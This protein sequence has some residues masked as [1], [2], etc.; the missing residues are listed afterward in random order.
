M[1]GGIALVLGYGLDW[2]GITPII[3]RIAT[4][5]FTFASGGWALVALAFFYWLVD[6]KKVQSWTRFFIVV[7]MNSIFIYLFAEV[8]GKAW[9]VDFVKIFNFGFFGALGLTESALNLLNALIT[10]GCMWGLC[11]FLYKKKI[12]FRV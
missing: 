2:L 12:F 4:T 5:S 6:V 8:L 1:A 10:L 11:Y 7:G 9:L 3:K